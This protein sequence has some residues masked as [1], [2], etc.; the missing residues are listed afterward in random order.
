MVQETFLLFV[1]YSSAEFVRPTQARTSRERPSSLDNPVRSVGRHLPPLIPSTSMK[2]DPRETM[3][4]L[5]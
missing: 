1:G 2:Q 3:C 5:R 4:G